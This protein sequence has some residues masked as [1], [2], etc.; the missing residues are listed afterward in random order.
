MAR[1]T[2]NPTAALR[3]LLRLPSRTNLTDMS[4]IGQSSLDEMADPR[5]AEFEPSEQDLMAAQEAATVKTPSGSFVTP[6]RESVQSSAMSKVKALLGMQDVEAKQASDL[7]A[8]KQ[9]GLTERAGIAAK[10]EAGAR[11][12]FTPLQTAEGIQSFDTRTGKV[13]GRL[14]DYKPAASAEEALTNA[15]SVQADI[16]RIRTQFKPELVGPLMGRYNSVEQALVGGN[17]DITNLYQTSQRLHNT[18]VYLRT[19]KQMN[20]SEA[21]R[22]LAELPGKNER[23]DVFLTK[24]NNVGTYFDEW[25]QNRAR[26]AFGR[27]TTGD[28]DRLT[29]TGGVAPTGRSSAADLIKKYGR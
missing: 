21:S 2:D 1:Q 17:P 9:A 22:I 5:L 28:V 12:Y 18:I 10:T 3:Q 20:E 26:L 25:M 24:L 13:A 27:T 4:G 14:G 29:G 8:Q 11:P 19:G 16:A 6:S 23:P 7:E 15:Q